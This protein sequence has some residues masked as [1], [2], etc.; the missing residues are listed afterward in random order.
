MRSMKR[1]IEYKR[2]ELRLRVSQLKGLS[3]LEKLEQGLAY[4]SK[5]DGNVVY[6][7]DQVE[8]GEILVI[9]VKDGKIQA[10]V[11]DK[12]QTDVK[13]EYGL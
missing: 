12:E 9:Q 8:Q 13:E 11:N 2:S 10:V 1:Q 3:P 5:T 7:V 4:V 6:S